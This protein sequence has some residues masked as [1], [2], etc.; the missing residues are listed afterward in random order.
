MTPLYWRGSS[1]PFQYARPC[2]SLIFEGAIAADV[3]RRPMVAKIKEEISSCIH[4]GARMRI[5]RRG[6]YTLLYV[7]I[8]YMFLAM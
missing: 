8:V 2:Y 4:G 6:T 5:G 7:A 1:L 3:G